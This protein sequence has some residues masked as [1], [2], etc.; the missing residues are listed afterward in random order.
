MKN[1]LLVTALASSMALAGCASTN[2]TGTTSQDWSKTAVGAL[3]GAAL[4]AG[5]S[6][7]TGGE[8]TGRDAAIGAAIGAGVGYYM[9][10][11]AQQL[12]TQ[13]AG[14]G[15][16]V[17]LDP[18]TN[19]IKLTM[20]SSITFDTAKSDV[21]PAFTGTLN[22][23]AATLGQYNQTNI[24]VMGHTDSDG[25]NAYNQNLSEQRARAV[26]SYIYNKGVAANR[27][28]TIGYGETRPVATNATAAGKAE[29]RRVEIKINAPSSVS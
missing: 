27:I 15:V 5:I 9:Q 7:A 23:L 28:S 2:T 14:T 10:Q 24:V 17:A 6:K 25:S 19:D 13:M 4:G 16:D 29:N 8:E 21:K 12:Q 18:N 11:Q 1:Q 20:P 3:A 26:A 22:D